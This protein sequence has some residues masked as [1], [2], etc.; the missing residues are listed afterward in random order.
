[1]KCGIRKTGDITLFVMRGDIVRGQIEEL[2]KII[3]N[4]MAQSSTS[5]VLIDLEG[6][7]MIDSTGVGFIVSI[8]K[9]VVSRNGIFGISRSNETVSREFR[10]L[11]LTRFFKIYESED[12]AILAI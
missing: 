10:I 7:G 1:M 6:V 4:E 3:M 12:E 2:R 11:G 5:K 9:A 8:Y